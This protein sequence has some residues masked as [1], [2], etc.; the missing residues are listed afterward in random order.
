MSLPVQLSVGQVSIYGYGQLYN[1]ANT[2][3]NA[4]SLQY[5]VVVQ[6]Y[7][8]YGNASIGDSICYSEKDIEAMVRYNEVDYKIINEEKIIYIENPVITKP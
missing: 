2:S 7:N 8:Q 5:G 4:N 1:I 6:M 3:N